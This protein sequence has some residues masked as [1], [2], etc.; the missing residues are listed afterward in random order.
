M[1]MMMRMRT[2]MR[3][4]MMMR[5]RMRIDRLFLIWQRANKYQADEDVKGM[6]R[7]TRT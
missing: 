4:R 7:K 1:M 2:R 5:M 6:A 3:M